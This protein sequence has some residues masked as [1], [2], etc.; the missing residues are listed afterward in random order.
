MSNYKKCMFFLI[1]LTFIAVFSTPLMAQIGG[2]AKNT[3]EAVS[4]PNPD[5][6]DY[7]VPLPCN[8]TMAFRVI[9]IRNIG[10]TGEIEGQFGT[11]PTPGSDQ[12]NPFN[13]RH[14]IRLGSNMSISELPTTFVSKAQMIL[15]QS[16]LDPSKIRQLYFI[17]KYE[18][19]NG[20]YQ[21]IMNNN[22]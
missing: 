2:V 16:N 17:G 20:Q 5:E 12:G 8:L 10:Y 18:V 15:E 3:P 7:I 19:S 14:L 1:T 22:C 6:F 11:D 13:K 4:N 21:A 9:F